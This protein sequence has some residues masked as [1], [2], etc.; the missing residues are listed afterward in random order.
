MI[1]GLTLVVVLG[2]GLASSGIPAAAAVY[3]PAEARSATERLDRPSAAEARA[4]DELLELS[5]LRVQLESLSAGVRVQ[6]LRGRGRMSAQ[7]R[8]TIDRIVS[9]NFDAER[10]YARIRLEFERNLDAAKLEAALAWYRSP[11]GKRMTGFELAALVFDGGRDA[12]DFVAHL[13]QH[14]PSA[15][16]IA[17]IERLDAGGGA[18]EATVDVTMAVVRG[19][20]FAFNPVLPAGARM[21]HD[22][23]ESRIARARGATLEQIRRV[24]LISML[25][26]YRSVPDHE[27]DHYVRFVE[28]EAG[29]WYVNVM[30]SALVTAMSVAA[31]TTAAELVTAL[32]Q[33]VGD[34]R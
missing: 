14:Q 23:L 15:R 34:L 27:L 8:A 5:G 1:R 6:F 33:L 19:L 32:P 30:N 24:C 31:E 13:E 16:R 17:L 26:A 18:S 12:A 11:L 20:A 3:R 22:Q 25:F 28:S 9:E 10:L 4:L 29:R 21:S 2:A 7:D